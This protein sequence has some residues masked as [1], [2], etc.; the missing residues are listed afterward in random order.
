MPF[1]FS[2]QVRDPNS[3]A[4]CAI[5]ETPHGIIET[6]AFI[7]VGTQAAVKSLTPEDLKE[8]CVQIVLGNTYHLYVRPGPD[9]IQEM[10]GLHR[11][12][13]WDG[14]I[15]TD[16][17]GFQIFSLGDAIK[18][19]VGKI[20]NIFP[21]ESFQEAKNT[22]K[23]QQGKLVKIDEDGVTFAS[24][25]DGSVH[26]LTPEKSIEI[27]KMLGPDIILAFD[28]CTSPFASYEY[29]KKALKR[30]HRWAIRCLEATQMKNEKRRV[31]NTEQALF[32]I[33]Q[34]GEYEDLRK[35]SAKLISSMPFDG[36]AIGGSL[37]KSKKDMESVLDW[38]IPFLPEEKP[39]HLLGIGEV[40]DILHAV[41]R[42]IDLFDCVQ[43]TRFGRTGRLTTSQG[44]I[45]I[46]NA[47]FRN[48]K[49][50]PD[51]ACS[52]RV[53]A[54][55]SRA[56]LHYLFRAK[57]LLAYRLASYHNLYFIHHLF[58]KIRQAIKQGT[59]KSF[60]EQNL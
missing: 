3:F 59:F 6:P 12:M 56:Y 34:G 48:D 46:C 1:R 5:Y 7:T 37:G 54:C 52:C 50:P 40:S 31:K 25:I 19:G 14:P 27:Q 29:T 9:L 36:F 28:E 17:G 53:C 8:I 15:I 2:I 26:R 44:N 47:N 22:N 41:A 42:G 21:E 51:P 24:H 55:F 49:H 38:V 60:K 32:G 10:G 4:R 45:D 57:E 35:E 33:V 11:F 23:E 13:G 16:S 58:Y 39:R 20:A 43:P 18:H 30:T